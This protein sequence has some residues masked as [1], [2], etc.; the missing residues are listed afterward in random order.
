VK[1]WIAGVMF[2]L[3]ALAAA[4]AYAAG[5]EDIHSFVAC[6][7]SINTA[8]QTVADAVACVPSGCYTTL[9]LSE[10]SAQPGCTLR[11][12]TRLPRVIFSCPGPGGSQT[13]RFRPSFTLCTQ[14]RT[15]INHIEVGE[16]VNRRHVQKMADIDSPPDVP[17]FQ[18]LTE[19][20][21]GATAV[22]DTKVPDN[23]KG[24]FD[25]HDRM[26]TVSTFGTIIN[27]FAS[28]RPELAEGTIYT[29]D[30]GVVPPAIQTPLSDI[31]AGIANSSQLARN[32]SRWALAASLCN[33][34][35]AK[36]H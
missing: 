5:P 25:C 19:F 13:L 36:T 24:C 14:G 32:P 11:D 34:L 26:G 8:Q 21:T 35:E 3:L 29:N 31:C 10:E 27:L 1:A 6:L 23:N 33:Q 4:P 12:G 2:S 17:S 18:V 15:L 16:D 22:V 28:V 7:N 20:G 9:T 30:P